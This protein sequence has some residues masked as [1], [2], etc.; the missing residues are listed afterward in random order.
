[1]QSQVTF[2]SPPTEQPSR[3]RRAGPTS[4]TAS[5]QWALGALP[6]RMAPGTGQTWAPAKLLWGSSTCKVSGFPPPGL[7]P[8]TGLMPRLAALHT[9][10]GRLPS[11]PPSLLCV[12]Q[13]SDGQ[14]PRVGL[15]HPFRMM[16]IM[17]PRRRMRTASPPAQMPRMSPISSDLWDTSRGCL[18]SLQA[19]G[20]NKAGQRIRGEIRTT[21]PL[22]APRNK[23]GC[24]KR[25][26]KT[27]APHPLQCLSAFQ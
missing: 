17:A 7:G 16:I 25:S 24:T 18:L 15:T 9:P 11:H 6:W 21:F 1:M 3:H 12:Q 13:A 19:A 14:K 2:T 27:T 10:V 4:S 22:P 8:S 23:R 20:E 26:T 5:W